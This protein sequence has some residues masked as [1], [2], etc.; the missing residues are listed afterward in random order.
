MTDNGGRQAAATGLRTEI[1][2]AIADLAIAARAG[3]LLKAYQREWSWVDKQN[4][5]DSVD[6]EVFNDTFHQIEGE[7]DRLAQILAQGAGGL[8]A[9][10]YDPPPVTLTSQQRWVLQTHNL[11]S[12]NLLVDV[13]LELPQATK[14]SLIE[15]HD[16]AFADLDPAQGW[17][18]GTKVENPAQEDTFSAMYILPNLNQIVLG[19]GDSSMTIPE[20]GLTVSVRIWKW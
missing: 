9:P 14:E 3:T 20:G 4:Y 2:G 7:F 1:I 11:N 10:D 15:L 13:K 12:T 19:A 18:A 5:V 6:A 8:P 16:G 17:V